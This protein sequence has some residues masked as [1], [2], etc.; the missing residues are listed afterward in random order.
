MVRA[1]SHPP[2]ERNEW[3]RS[4]NPLGDSANREGDPALFGDEKVGE[5]VV[6]GDEGSDYAQ[7]ATSFRNWRAVK[8]LAWKGRRSMVRVRPHE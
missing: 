5:A 1:R 8:E 3:K 7:H 4:V 2:F 6:I